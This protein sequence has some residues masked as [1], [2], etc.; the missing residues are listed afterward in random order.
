M[1]NMGGPFGMPDIGAD[2][3]VP[4]IR[5]IVSGQSAQHFFRY[6]GFFV[7]ISLGMYV[8]FFMFFQG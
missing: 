8:Y 5:Q 1:M 2:V 3:G 4:R 6:V 7:V